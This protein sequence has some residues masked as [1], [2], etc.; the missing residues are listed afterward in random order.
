MQ[1]ALIKAKIIIEV[2]KFPGIDLIKYQK[3]M[4]P[5]TID[6][7]G[8][9]SLLIDKFPEIS[10]HN[11]TINKVAYETIVKLSKKEV[12]K[13][14]FFMFL[15]DYSAAECFPFAGP[16]GCREQVDAVKLEIVEEVVPQYLQL[17]F[18]FSLPSYNLCLPLAGPR[19]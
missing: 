9:F 12:I 14:I 4:F 16:L 1:A 17:Y 19:G 3:A 5:T 11:A 18:D 10:R 8:E 2:S 6:H 13:S 7:K 15:C